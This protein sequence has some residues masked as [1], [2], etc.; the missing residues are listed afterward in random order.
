MEEGYALLQ[1]YPKT[2]LRLWGKL[3]RGNPLSKKRHPEELKRRGISSVS[4]FVTPNTVRGLL[5]P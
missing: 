3:E 5:F 1:L 4:P 2:T